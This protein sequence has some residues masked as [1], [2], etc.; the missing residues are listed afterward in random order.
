MNEQVQRTS[1]WWGLGLILFGAGL[2]LG[3]YLF[4]GTWE[5]VAIEVGAAAGVGG[6]VLLFKPRL[7]RQVKQVA[8]QAA[9]D[10]T[11][12]LTRRVSNLENINDI[13]ATEIKRQQSET[14]RLITATE[15]EVTFANIE[16]MLM[17]AYHQGFFDERV[18]VKTNTEL[19]KPL[20][21]ISPFSVNR[22]DQLVAPMHQIFFRVFSQVSS[23]HNHVQL[24]PIDQGIVVW[25]DGE[26]VQQ[27]IGKIIGIYTRTRLPED[28][29]DS[30]LVFSNLIDSFRLMSG[31]LRD[32]ESE[33]RRPTGK[34]VFYINEEWAL[35][36]I[37]L[38][39]T[40]SQNIFTPKRNEYGERVEIDIADTPRPPDC[41]DD[42]WN[43]AKAYMDNMKTIVTGVATRS[44]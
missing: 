19:G 36:D 1:P 31:T 16:A 35:T 17:H 32:T 44:G 40:R 25:N 13:Q 22:E 23:L 29:L 10:H 43:E 34:L 33:T 3:G 24:G 26:E 2:V 37:G 41:D 7:M 11:E 30:N 38:E 14:E 39:S 8:T 21:E 20:L 9:A 28:E 27:I 42:Q 5:D 18:L 15:E 4:E 12:P 6:I